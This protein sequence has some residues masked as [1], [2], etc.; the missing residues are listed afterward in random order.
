MASDEAEFLKGKVVWANW[1]INELKLQKE[2]ICRGAD[3]Q[4][5]R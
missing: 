2:A 3:V 1:D 5:A 4:W